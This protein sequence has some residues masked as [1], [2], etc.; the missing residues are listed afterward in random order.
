MECMWVS[1]DTCKTYVFYPVDLDDEV[2]DFCQMMPPT[3][4]LSA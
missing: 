4:L 3:K 1:H 2:D